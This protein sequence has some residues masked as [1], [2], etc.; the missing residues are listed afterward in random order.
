MT[1]RTAAI[2][3]LNKIP[4]LGYL[5]GAK[6]QTVEKRELLILITPRVIGTALDAARIT[7]EMRRAT[8]SWTSRSG[9]RRASP[10]RCR[11]RGSPPRRH[12]RPRPGRAAPAPVPGVDALGAPRIARALLEER[13]EPL[14]VVVGRDRDACEN[15]SRS[16]AAAGRRGGA[17]HHVLGEREHLD[18]P[19]AIRSASAR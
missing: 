14:L 19:A 18:G 9:G 7:D 11:R 15:A 4:V 16:R 12:R 2:P 5:F 3:Y 8:P 17:V 13:G 1:T 10:T 6:Q